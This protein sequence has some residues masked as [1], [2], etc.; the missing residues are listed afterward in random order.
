MVHF[1]SNKIFLTW[2]YKRGQIILKGNISVRSFPEVV[3]VYPDFAV[4]VNPVKTDKHFTVCLIRRNYKRFTI[5]SYSTR[6]KSCGTGVGFIEISFDAPVVRQIQQMPGRIIQPGILAVSY[7][8]FVK[9]PV[10]IKIL[11]LPSGCLSKDIII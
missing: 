7:V 5:P 2:N 4:I 8:T 6:Q 9:F 1:Y 10:E 11:H 3:S